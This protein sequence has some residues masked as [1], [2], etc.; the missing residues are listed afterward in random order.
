MQNSSQSY[1]HAYINELS[2]VQ[3]G[4]NHCGFMY[5]YTNIH[6]YHISIKNDTRIWTGKEMDILPIWSLSLSPPLSSLGWTWFSG[7][8]GLSPQLQSQDL[9]PY[10]YQQA[11]SEEIG[12]STV[13]LTDR[14]SFIYHPTTNRL[15]P[16]HKVSQSRGLSG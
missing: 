16:R 15:S 12:F 10:K 1:M 13:Q 6:V 3:N 2:C 4:S 9:P 14:G 7:G 8:P 11:C 5:K